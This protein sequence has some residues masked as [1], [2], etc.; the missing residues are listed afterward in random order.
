MHKQIKLVRLEFDAIYKSRLEQFPE[1]LQFY[2][3][4][5]DFL[6]IDSYTYPP[7]PRDMDYSEWSELYKDNDKLKKYLD[8]N[9]CFAQFKYTMNFEQY[10]EFDFKHHN[11]K[12][13]YSIVDRFTTKVE[14]D[15]DLVDVND[16]FMLVQNQ[17]LEVMKKQV[18]SIASIGL[19]MHSCQHYNER[20][21]S[22]V[23]DIFLHKVNQTMVLYDCC[24]D[25]LQEQISKGWRI[26]SVTPQPNQR[27]PDY[28]LGIVMDEN[29][30]KS[31]AEREEGVW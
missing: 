19:G 20:C 28:V 26:I 30:I 27:R 1:L 6:K 12:L 18:D 23:S 29:E 3:E 25:R 8:D 31:V 11:K 7:S 13:G 4:N 24:S 16:H 22:P 21:N 10:G 2:M 14:Y 5:T 17:I 15:F 9:P